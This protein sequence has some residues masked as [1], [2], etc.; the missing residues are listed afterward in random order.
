M[1]YWYDLLFTIK[2]L[3]FSTSIISICLVLMTVSSIKRTRLLEERKRLE[4]IKP[5]KS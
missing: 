3:T 2:I 4:R 1:N 5:S